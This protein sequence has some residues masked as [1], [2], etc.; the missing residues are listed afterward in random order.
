MLPPISPR[1]C[2][3]LS[4]G[5]GALLLPVVRIWPDV[6]ISTCELDPENIKKL[7][8]NFKGEH[9]NIDVLSEDFDSVFEGRFSSFD[10]AVS[11]PPFSWRAISKYDAAILEEFKLT[12]VFSGKRVRSEVLFIL[13]YVRLMSRSSYMAFILPELVV[14]S[15]VLGKFRSRLLEFCTVVSVSEV[16][17]GAFKGTEAKTYIVILKKDVGA[18]AFTYTDV[19]GKTVIKEQKDFCSGLHGLPAS[20]PTE[21]DDAFTVK[22]GNL[23]GKECKSLGLPYYH[24][25]GFFKSADGVI[26]M[27]LESAVILGKKPLVACKGDVLIGRV[28][29]RVVGRAVLSDG[30]YIV[31]DC[32]FRV[33]FS[34]AIDSNSFLKH[35]MDNCYLKVIS[36]ARGTCAKYITAQDL[37]S[38]IREFIDQHG[39][40]PMLASR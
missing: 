13:Q 36:Q 8:S 1:H 32:V 34:N 23:S 6:R 25:S 4:A 5:E 10:F 28:G 39:H 35:W 29:S 37:G 26:P 17:V 12:D 11:N 30:E 3:E 40:K 31:S 27:P 22:R 2:I 38:H 9:Y 21:C 7:A 24:T 33:R 19:T 15:S 14:C 16:E 20:L 18:G